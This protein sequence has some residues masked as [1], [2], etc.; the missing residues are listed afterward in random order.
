MGAI[1]TILPPF[2]LPLRSQNWRKNAVYNKKAD[3]L[4]LQHPAVNQQNIIDTQRAAPIMTAERHA[5]G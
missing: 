1:L 4:F 3:W 2:C 5:D